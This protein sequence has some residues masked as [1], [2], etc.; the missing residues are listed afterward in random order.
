MEEKKQNALNN[1]FSRFKK[2][3]TGAKVVIISGVT[4]CVVAIGVGFLY[5]NKGQYTVLFSNLSASDASEVTTKLDEL[6]TKYQVK[7]SNNGTVTI[8]VPEKDSANARI[9]VSAT[10]EPSDGVVGYEI[11]DTT[12][13]G[14]TQSDRNQKQIRA[15]EGEIT[16]TLQKLPFIQWARVHINVASN[17]Y[18]E[19]NSEESTAS[20]TLQ[21]ADNTTLSKKQTMGI[22]KIVS[23]SV[24]GLK[25]QNVEV[26]DNNATLLSDGL[27]TDDS[28]T[29]TDDEISVEKEKEK[30]VR[31]KVQNLLNTVVG[32]GNAVV[33]VDLALNFDKKE[34][35]EQILGDKVA[36]SE[37]E[38]TKDTNISNGTQEVPGTDSNAD[39]ED[40]TANNTAGSSINS[41]NYAETQT[42]YEIEKRNEK[43]VVASGAIEKM[44]LSVV[45]NEEAIADENGTI[46]EALK[47]QLI[48]NVKNAAGFDED[49]KDSISLT[50]TKFNKDLENETNAQLKR[51]NTK[52]L[53]SKG[54]IGVVAL[55]AL[56]VLLFL[57]KKATDSIKASTAERNEA[58]EELNLEASKDM[59]DIDGIVSQEESILIEQRINKTIDSNPEDAVKAIR[60]MMNNTD[61]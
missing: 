49:R 51:E 5:S 9:E 59:P 8:M 10:F 3:G 21:L 43:T 27:F 47:N 4:L 61:L 57:I 52:V 42:N 32:R 6:K 7:E 12:S 35:A 40:Y 53:V 34:I 1:F 24:A 50:V 23:N 26:L 22:I 39:Q 55:A 54:I 2:L 41:E 11:L 18:L 17:S 31:E 29:S 15:L 19:T 56:G 37:K 16:K 60:F 48:E 14:E 44:T 25:P 20:I 46:D 58:V 38:I 45:L 28:Y 13:F 36:V 33:E 30:L